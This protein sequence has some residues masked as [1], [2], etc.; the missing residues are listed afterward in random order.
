MSKVGQALA[1]AGVTVGRVK[2]NGRIISYSPL[3]R[4]IELEA[5]ASG[6]LSK[7]RLWESLLHVAEVDPRLDKAALNRHLADAKEQLETLR[8]LHERAIDD[9]F[10]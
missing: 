1:V 7:L 6:V 10:I 8:S 4:V 3:S 9:A 5:M 2:M